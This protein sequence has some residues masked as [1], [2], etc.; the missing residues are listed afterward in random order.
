MQ[1]NSYQKNKCRCLFCTHSYTYF[2]ALMYDE[3]EG[4]NTR[5][6][7]ARANR[8]SGNHPALHAMIFF[9][10]VIPPIAIS[11]RG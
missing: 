9:V 6:T 7:S 2:L 3:G 5:V 1:G 4:I 8:N 10:P 11:L